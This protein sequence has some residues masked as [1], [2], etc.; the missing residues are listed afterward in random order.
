MSLIEYLKPSSGKSIKF[1]VNEIKKLIDGSINVV[2]LSN[3]STKICVIIGEETLESYSLQKYATVFVQNIDFVEAVREIPFFKI[4]SK[5]KNCFKVSRKKEK[6]CLEF[7]RT[8][9]DC[10]NEVDITRYSQPGETVESLSSSKSE[11]KPTIMKGTLSLH[12]FAKSL[13]A[14]FSKDCFI[15]VDNC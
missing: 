11:A 7:S 8:E 4:P 10:A 12:E 5:A 13:P 1:K 2:Y 14:Q 9:L 3:A 6:T 15:E